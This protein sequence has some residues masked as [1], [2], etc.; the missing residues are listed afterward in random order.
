MKDFNRAR[1]NK[2]VNEP[3]TLTFTAT[4]TD[5]NLPANTLTHS[6]LDT[7]QVHF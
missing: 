1:K 5:H 3:E 6:L 2:N 7:G 4:A